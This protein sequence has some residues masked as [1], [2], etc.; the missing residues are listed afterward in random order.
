M[1]DNET[2]KE[3]HRVVVREVNGILIIIKHIFLFKLLN[4]L[5]KVLEKHLLLVKVCYRDSI[6][7]EK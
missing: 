3:D 4:P 7:E 1:P 2:G 5:V 6:E